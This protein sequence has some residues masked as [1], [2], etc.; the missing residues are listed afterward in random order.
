MKEIDF[1]T[2][3]GLIKTELD[4]LNIK[5][6]IVF[7]FL[8]IIIAIVNWWIQ[9]NVKNI[10][11]KIYKNKV[12][13][14]RRIKIIEEI[15]GELVSFTY[16]LDKNEMVNSISKVSNLQKKV[17][18]NRLYIDSKMNDKITMFIDYLKNLMSDFRHKDFREEQKMLTNIEKEFNK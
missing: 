14:D 12:R 11:N 16:I 8:N 5:Y 1:K 4:I 17:S 7:I 15:Y 13:E 3:Q 9:R 18:E 6:I 10:D 2:L